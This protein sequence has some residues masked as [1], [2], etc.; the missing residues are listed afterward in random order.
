MMRATAADWSSG[1]G[2][3]PEAINRWTHGFGF[4]ASVP[5]AA[6]LFRTALSECDRQVTVAFAVYCVALVGLYA[7]SALSHAFEDRPHIRSRFRTADQVC[8]Y[9]MIAGTFTPFAAACL[10]TPIGIAQLVAMWVLACCGIW[11]RVRSRGEQVGLLDVG[12][13]LVTGW[14]PVV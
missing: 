2:V 8:I 12:L 10:W 7:A 5:A 14:I 3:S 1:R 13:C 6:Y 9:L 11:H 4:A